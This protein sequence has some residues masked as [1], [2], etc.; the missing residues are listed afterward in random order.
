MAQYKG[1]ASEAGRAMQ[2]MKKREKEREQLEQLKQKI[3]EDNM[4][5]SNIDKKFSAHY[6]AVE[7][8]LKSS[9]VGLVTLNDMK[10]KQE[11]L[12]KEREKQLAK[13]EQSKELQ[14]KLEKQKEKKRK[15]E[16]KRKIAS[17]SFN[18][19]DEEEE[20]EE[21]EE[22][23]QDYVPA[24][25]KLG[26]NPDVDTSFLP[27][28]DREEE[29]NRLREELRQEWELKQ[30]KIKSEEIEITFSYWD[31][32]GHRKTVKMKKGNTIQNFLQRALEVLRKDFSE[33]RSAGVE[34]LMYIK[35]DLIIPHHHSFYDFI[36]TKARGKS[37]PLFSFDVHDDIRLVNDATVEKDESH[38]GK[39]VLRSWY[40][41][42]KHIFPASRWEPYDPEKKWDK[43]TW[44]P[45][46]WKTYA[47]LWLN[48]NGSDETS[49]LSPP[50]SGIHQAIF[51]YL[52]SSN[53]WRAAL[54]LYQLVTLARSLRAQ[55]DVT[56]AAITPQ[57]CTL[58]CIRQGG[59]GCEYCRI[60]RVDVKQ[61]LGFT[62]IAP[63]GRIAFLRGFQVS[64]QAL[65][66]S[67]VACQL[68]LFHRNL[69]LPASQAQKVYKSDPFPGL[70]L[71]SQFAVTVMALP[72]P[73]KWNDFY[74]SKIFSTRS[75]AEKNGHE[76]CKKDWYPKQVEVHQEGSAVNVTFNLAPPILGI[77][78]YFSFC[79]ANGMKKYTNIT[80]NLSENKTHHSYQLHD[81]QEGTNYTCEIAA[82]EVDAV[83]KVFHV[84]VT[85]IN[86]DIIKQHQES[87]TQEEV[88]TLPKT[89]LT[90]PR[91]LFCY[92]SYD[93]PAHVKAVMQ[94]GAF[95]Q[96]HMATQVCLDLWDSLSVAEEGSMAWYCR[97]IRESDFIL[98]ICSRGLRHRP[99]SPQP[100]GD[101]E[102]IEAKR[103]LNQVSNAFSSDAAIQLIGEEVGRAKATGQDL[104]K[105]MAAIFEYSEETDIPTELRLVSHYTLTRDLPLLFSH[106]HG[107]AL[108]RPG[109][110]L[111]IN[112]MSEEGFAKLPAGAALQWAI[113]EAGVA[114][115]AKRH[116]SLEGSD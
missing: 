55:D 37:G 46:A 109:G 90:P 5:K 115:R 19:E 73:E 99:E 51:F 104:S 54:V 78:N 107:V 100:E 80:P 18:P 53:M 49:P 13:K 75:C 69:S 30:E 62:A 111:K 74:Q 17:L 61:A 32:S 105:Y 42:N 6:D 87:G 85:H 38:A 60:T 48:Y 26:K 50:L 103:G 43:Y 41:K 25:K 10:A 64:L 106:L 20:E 89:R 92:S 14:L 68:F 29:E 114:M 108:H 8:E 2:L 11:A 77:T 96:Q 58:D 16:Q 113:N 47:F 40:E 66:G 34:Q 83:R 31:G 7:A 3:A 39:V 33:L 44:N 76:K 71:G 28:R 12:V 110:Y 112:H 98:V 67:A 9:T 57:D 94:L 36:V 82:N 1:A 70:P 65:G 15:E 56:A 93:G 88:V 45:C 102:D 35:E 59:P 4:V 24:K 91:L 86:K 27:D 63:F 116:Q 101:D 81:L 23:E 21:N 72:V 97:Q 52:Q 22:E 84:Q 95:I 79:Y